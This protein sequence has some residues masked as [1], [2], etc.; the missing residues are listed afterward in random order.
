[1]FN[2]KTYTMKIKFSTLV[3][4]PFFVLLMLTSCQEEKVEVSPPAD[5]EALVSDSELTSLISSAAKMDGSKD[6]IID[7]ASCISIKFPF[8]V[9]VRGL[10]IRISSEADYDLVEAIYD[11]FDDDEDR[12]DFIFPI[13]I[14]NAGHEEIVINNVAELVKFVEECGGENEEDDD[15]ECIDFQYPISFSIFSPDFDVID[16]VTIENDRQLHLFMKRV[17]NSDVIASLNFPVTMKLSDGTTVQANSNE[18]LREIIKEAKD[19]CDEDDD[20]DYNDDDFTKERLD[21]YLKE[22][23]WVVFEFKRDNQENTDQYA[24]YAINFKEEGVVTMKAR[25]GDVLTG[26]WSTRV[27]DRGALL[28]MEFESLADFTL[29]WFVYDFEDG[30]IKIFEEG[31]NRIVLKR[32]CDVVVDI[33][34]ERVENFLKECFWR[35]ARLHVDGADNE[36]EYIGTPLKFFE[37]NQVKIRVDGELVEGTYE[38][39]VRNT[40]IG[41]EINLEGRP[42]LKLQW[43]ITFLGEDFIKLHNANNEMILKRNC[44]DNDEDIDFITEILTNGVWE[45]ASYMVLDADLT[46][47]YNDYVIGFDEN[48]KVS[49]EGDG[50]NY[51]GSWFGYRYEGLNLGLN[52]RPQDELFSE[53]THRWKIKE[54]TFN[55]I[56][57]KDYNAN[58]EIER[59]LVLENIQ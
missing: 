28:K 49:A 32:N 16:T 10:E 31:G 35:V 30:K 20:N 24:Q 45:I 50:N 43:V 57:L 9:K 21:E 47:N 26:E 51:I 33:T 39:L 13:T 2:P 37:N 46:D 53:L 48:G 29:E 34:K 55:I 11:E 19:A 36:K 59:I 54:I 41:L 58:G 5:S 7:N 8:I 52:F 6:N 40:G 22:C 1:M 27:T 42:D 12:L 25:N 18:E 15:I 23:P 56:E 38:V 44:N 17:R 3:L 4:L 14:I